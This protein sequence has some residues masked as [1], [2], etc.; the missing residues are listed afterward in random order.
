MNKRYEHITTNVLLPANT[1]TMEEDVR[2]PKGRVI[3]MGVLLIGTMIN[4]FINMSVLDNNNEVVKPLDARFAE[5]TTGGDFLDCFMPVD[6]DGS[7]TYQARLTATAVD[8]VN[9]VS[10]QFI[11]I[12]EKDSESC[13]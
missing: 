9:A 7:R 11:F 2:I 10:A 3:A 13:A 5:K 4:R 6:F 1:I 8:N 12:V